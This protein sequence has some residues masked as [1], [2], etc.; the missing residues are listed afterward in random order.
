MNKLGFCPTLMAL[1]MFLLLPVTTNAAELIMF[2]SP[3]CSWCEA[4]ENEIGD[5]YHKTNEG[6]RAPLRRQSIH[7]E[8][9]PDLNYLKA[10][11]YTPTFILISQ[12]KEIGRIN[13]YPGEESFWFLLNQLIGKL[14][15]KVS[16]CPAPNQEEN[17]KC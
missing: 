5:I 9:P 15:K 8:I 17:V 13:G 2:D 1:A 3:T 14:D 4:W 6:K 10:I 12:G 16:A 7:D 11:R